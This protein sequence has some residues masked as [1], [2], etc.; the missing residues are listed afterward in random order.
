MAGL[1]EAVMTPNVSY[2]F[3]L[4]ETA[5]SEALDDISPNY[6]FVARGKL[7]VS[8]DEPV[9][10]YTYN[11]LESLR[12]VYSTQGDA[13]GFWGT[14]LGYVVVIFSLF[15]VVAQPAEGVQ[16]GKVFPSQADR[17]DFVYDAID[18]RAVLR[19]H[20]LF[21]ADGVYRAGVPANDR[22]AVVL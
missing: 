13:H 1:F 16:A 8:N 5:L 4:T 14:T 22:V 11:V 21:A 19:G 17:A 20:A 18:F 6:G 3:D 9:S 2:D 7:I 10:D 15:P 12:K